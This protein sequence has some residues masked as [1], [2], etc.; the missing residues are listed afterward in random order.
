MG[1]KRTALERRYISRNWGGRVCFV[2][3]YNAWE[4]T[5]A[6]K[7]KGLLWRKIVYIDI[8]SIWKS[9]HSSKLLH[10]KHGSFW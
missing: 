3:V 5:G 8:N 6:D 2:S 1:F 4:K 7:R 9:T 10:L